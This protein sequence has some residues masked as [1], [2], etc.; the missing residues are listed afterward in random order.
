MFPAYFSRLAAY[1]QWANGIL[2][3]AATALPIAEYMR[4]EGAHFGGLH[5]TLNHMVVTDRIWM[6]RLTGAGETYAALDARPFDDLPALRAAR[7]AEDRRIVD[8][9]SGLTDQAFEQPLSYTNTAGDPFISPLDL[10]LGHFFNHQTHHRGQAHGLITALGH[11]APSL[12]I[13]YFTRE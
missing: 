11:A 3:D 12:D 2:Y 1:N 4:D 5:A 9:V 6:R 10:V 8:W 7:E 13:I